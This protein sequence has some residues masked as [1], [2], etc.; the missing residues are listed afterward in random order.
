MKR[1][2]EITSKSKTRFSIAFLALAVLLFVQFGTVR[3][4][5][6]GKPDDTPP[7]VTEDIRDYVCLVNRYLHPNME[8]YFNE[9]IREYMQ[10]ASKDQNARSLENEKRGGSGSGFVYVDSNG[11]NYIITN[12]HVIEGGYR[13]SATF[14]NERGERLPPFRNLSVFSVDEQEDLAILAFPDGQKP[15]RRGIPV[16]TTQLRSGNPV[17]AA[18]YPGGIEDTPTWS[19]TSGIINNPSVR[20]QQEQYS[21]IL[22][23][24]TVNFGN[25]GGPLLV[26]DTLSHIGYSVAGVN[27]LKMRDFD[28]GNLAIPADRLNAFLQRSFQQ[29]VSLESRVNAFMALLERFATNQGQEVFRELSS[30]LSSTMINAEPSRAANAVTANSPAALRRE[31]ESNPVTGIAQAVAYSKIQQPILNRYRTALAQRGVKPEII[32]SEENNMGGYTVR[33][34]VNGYPY[35]AEW[36][37]EYGTWK[38]DDFAEDDRE[39][40]DYPDLANPHPMGKKV[41]YSFSSSVD[42]DWYTL[43]IPRPGR[44]TV[45]TEG[46]I[47][48]VLIIFYDPSIPANMQNPI[49]SDDDSGQGNNAFVSADV[50]AG[51]VWVCVYEA[52]DA[53]GEYILLAGLDGEIDNI[54]YT[55]ATA[56]TNTQTNNNPSITIVNN[57]GSRISA[58]YISETTS[59]SWGPN[60]LASN[61]TIGNGESASVQLPYP[62]NQINLYDIMVIDSSLNNYIK[63]NVQVTAN[64]RIV[65]T[66]AD[67]E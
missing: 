39:Y 67:R 62:I 18:G 56:T 41:V 26:R 14:E 17:D 4:Y 28:G 37:R 9:T 48:P 65:F 29:T 38:L 20:P 46:S 66:A 15:F 35:R 19:L 58:I 54:P 44:L 30:F 5:A 23:S 10:D 31:V 27:T 61:Q 6:G 7:P 32:S 52:V 57:T 53:L 25:S 2:T 42:V 47:D 11:N 16:S 36:I 51:T 21:Y 55:T 60:R 45:R 63:W 43:D 1:T 59:S 64:A 13:F 8:R 49:G 12:Y 33:F 22:H 3:L 40:N 24:A 50:R 34:L